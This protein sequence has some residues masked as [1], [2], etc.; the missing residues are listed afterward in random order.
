MEKTNDKMAKKAQRKSNRI[1]RA[2]LFGVLFVFLLGVIG[3]LI[4]YQSGINLRLKNHEEQVMLAASAQFQL[5]LIDLQNERYE[6]AKKRF[7]Y[8]IS[9]D[10]AFPGAEE[11]LS[12]ALL[13]LVFV[14]T[15]EPT[16]VIAALPTETP[17]P[18]ITPTVDPRPREEMFQQAEEF[19]DAGSWV[20]AIETLDKLRLKFPDD[21]VTIVDGMY[22]YAYRNLGVQKIIMEGNLEGGMYDL[23][24][25]ERFGVLD[26]EAD[27]YRTYARYFMTGI[28]FWEVDW[29]QSTY[30]FGLVANAFPNLHDGSN[31][32]AQKRFFMASEGYGDQLYAANEFCTARDNYQTAYDLEASEELYAKLAL[33][34]ENC[35]E[36]GNASEKENGN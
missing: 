15:A 23:A 32:T 16:A 7:E 19:L 21:Q 5:G 27:G 11:K 13:G 24:I 10:S 12:E 29:S 17:T 25:A 22:F 33:S 9:L 31:Y 34:I 3:G 6:M 30:Y 4:G 14:V 1:G 28:S 18:E 36:H 2:I 26:W 35:D 20:E 8:V